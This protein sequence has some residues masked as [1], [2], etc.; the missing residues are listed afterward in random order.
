MS[1][2]FAQMM[3]GYEP[4]VCPNKECFGYGDTVPAEHNKCFVCHTELVH[5]SRIPF[6]DLNDFVQRMLEV[7]LTL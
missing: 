5:Y 3:N 1:E 2:A 7:K 6:D 4:D